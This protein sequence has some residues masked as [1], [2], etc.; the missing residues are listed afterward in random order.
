MKSHPRLSQLLVETGAFKDL[1]TP[2]ILASGQLGIYYVNTEKLAQDGGK[3]NEY[4]DSSK[5]MIEHAVRMTQE[6]PTFGEVI[7]ILTHQVKRLTEQKHSIAISGGQRRDWLFS[8]PIAR[9]LK[10][11]HISIYKDGKVEEVLSEGIIPITSE[12]PLAYD[13]IVHVVDLLTEGSSCYSKQGEVESGWIP[14]IRKRGG[15]IENL[16]AVVTRLQKGEENLAAQGVNVH[17]N[18]AIDEDF[19]RQHSN[20]PGR[21]L[22]YN[23]SPTEWSQQYLNTHGATAL[24]PF[25]DPSKADQ[26]KKAKNFMGR[27]RDYLRGVHQFHPLN[28]ACRTK[29]GNGVDE[30]LA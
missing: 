16:V 9:N 24:L 19:L 15:K 20:N 13:F 14:E 5:A 21:A 8:G 10:I 17:A 18:V 22:V 2:V 30:I 23:N 12:G 4:G 3:F 26:L 7:D 11:P 25:F 6:H 27:Y 1:E 28:D 29:Y